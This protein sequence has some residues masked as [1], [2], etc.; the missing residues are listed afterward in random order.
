MPT[1]LLLLA[2]S[3][4]A[5]LLLTPAVRTLAARWGLVDR[6]DGRRK[7]QT[8]AIPVGGGLAVF[9]A[10][11]GA[12]AVFCFWP[13]P[14]RQH[15]REQLSDLIGLL[16]AAVLICGVGVADDFGCLRGRHKFLGQLLA[17]GVVMGFGLVVSRIRLFGWHVELGLL[18]VPFTAFWLLGA[19]NSLNLIDGMDGLLS[20]VGVIIALAMAATAVLFDKWPAACLAVALAGAL[21]GF[22]RYNFPPASIFLGDSGSMLIGLIVGVL[23]IRSSLKGPATIALAA[24]LAMLAIPAFDTLAAIVRRKLTG[25]SIYDTDRSH[26]HHCLLRRGLS[27]RLALLAIASFCLL[28]VLGALA[29]LAFNNEAYAVAASLAVIAGLVVTR[30]FGYAE[31][32][33]VKSRLTHLLRSLLPTNRPGV[34]HQAVVHVQG[35]ADWGELMEALVGSA[36]ELNLKNIRLDVNAPALHESYHGV[37]DCGAADLREL[38]LWRTELPLFLRGQIVGRLEVAGQRNGK[39]IRE[40]VAYIEAT[41]DRFEERFA[42]LEEASFRRAGSLACSAPQ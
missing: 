18:A 10:V 1:L 30:L 15:L 11:A 2:L 12:L 33:L 17:V 32:L 36:E 9:L 37:W 38:G 26:L 22:L 27:S 7:M 41:V 4:G 24:P 6:P 21:L 5:A 25:R 29:T 31:F 23:A 8:R 19:I 28:T 42:E 39:A 14:L 35:S 3:F 20:S 16:L 13:S 34:P 40:Q